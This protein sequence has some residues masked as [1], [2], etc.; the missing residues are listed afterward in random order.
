MT[1]R[2]RLVYEILLALTRLVVFRSRCCCYCLL[3]WQ[4]ATYDRE[5]ALA[6]KLSI[7][8]SGPQR[9]RN[10]IAAR[11]SYRSFIFILGLVSFSPKI[12]CNRTYEVIF[13]SSFCNERK[14]FSYVDPDFVSSIAVWWGKDT[15]MGKKIIF[16]E[17]FNV[18]CG[19]NRNKL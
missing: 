5:K 2:G 17:F 11:E 6:N 12:N 14:I 18:E 19:R 16:L 8:R 13:F 7:L 3:L 15:V 4:V 9:Y 1:N 10:I